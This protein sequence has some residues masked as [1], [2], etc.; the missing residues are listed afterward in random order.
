MPLRADEPQKP[1]AAP[2]QAGLSA[3]PKD[4]PTYNCDVL[5]TRH[6]RGEKALGKDNV[7]KLVEKWRY[8]PTFSLTFVGVIHATPVVVNGYVYFGTATLPA[9]YKL[10]P[11]GKLRWSYTPKSARKGGR[12]FGVPDEGFINSPLVT[13]DT[14][15]A[16]DAGGMIYALDRA[17][18]EK[19]WV[20]DTRS[21]PFPGAH[22]SNC[23][24][25]APVLAAGQLIIAGGGYEHALAASP[26]NRGCTGRGFVAALSPSTGKALWKY[27]VG[28]EPRPLNPPVKI[29]DDWGEKVYHLGPSTSSVWS[30][31]SYDEAS[32]QI[33]FG[34]DT[35]NAPR[36]PT[37]D[38]PRLYTKHSCAV[39]AL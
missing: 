24:F 5:G 1:K 14:V 30:T 16:A 8:P 21:A 38:D 27:D 2:K 17:T 25:A 26:K 34:T 37:N 10:T 20:V 36:Q 7:A 22:P 31:P 33:Y 4:W 23:I 3:D 29:K 15:Y 28:P 6:N 35:H 12:R 13:A 32:R 39:I 19:R 11:D 18:G 9:V